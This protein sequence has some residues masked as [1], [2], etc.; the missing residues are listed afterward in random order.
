MVWR[1]H[2]NS[3]LHFKNSAKHD[4]VVSN[5]QLR[6][7]KFPPIQRD[8]MKQTSDRK[9]SKENRK[10]SAK[11]DRAQD[12]EIDETRTKDEEIEETRAKD[13]R[14]EL[15]LRMVECESCGARVQ[16]HQFPKHLI[17]HFHYHRYEQS[18]FQILFYRYVHCAKPCSVLNWKLG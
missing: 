5:C 17:S 18:Y 13:E 8:R 10:N 11:T 12:N 15:K 6:N 9:S 16:S 14:S 1:R 7:S 2:L 3:E 4:T